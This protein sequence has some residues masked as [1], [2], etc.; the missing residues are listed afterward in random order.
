MTAQPTAPAVR[1]DWT[2]DQIDLIKR[3]IAKDATHDEL[4]LFLYQAKKTGLDPLSKQIYFQKYAGRV[5]I[6][7]AIDGYRLVAGRTGEHVGTSDAAFEEVNGGPVKATVTVKRLTHGVVGEYTASARMSEYKPK[8][9]SDHMWNKMPYAMLAKCAEALALRKAFPNEL[10]GTY[11]KEEMEQ[12]TP[13]EVAQTR[14]TRPAP[15]THTIIKPPVAPASQDESVSVHPAAPRPPVAPLTPAREALRAA[16]EAEPPK[17]GSAGFDK[18]G[19][20]QA[21][22]RQIEADFKLLEGSADKDWTEFEK[23]TIQVGPNMTK[24]VAEFFTP[25]LEGYLKKIQKAAV[26]KDPA[27]FSPTMRA[28]LSDLPYYISQRKFKEE[29]AFLA[30]QSETLHTP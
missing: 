29:Q 22:A 4:Q 28:L 3:T 25:D 9:P 10:S 1:V 16:L 19:A 15:S 2:P 23:I 30:S 8:P 26:G 20:W 18:H 24:G 12:A 21:E 11:T 5:T 27:S 13:D 6:I 7:T 17:K 14:P